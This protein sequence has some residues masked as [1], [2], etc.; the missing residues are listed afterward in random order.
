MN[1][2]LQQN[3]PRLVEKYTDLIISNERTPP[4]WFIR[5]FFCE[6]VIFYASDGVKVG[7]WSPRRIIY[8]YKTGLF[9]HMSW[10]I[11]TN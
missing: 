5:H 8:C 1:G 6:L 9:A 3:E 2:D 10:S 11:D 7:T 4:L